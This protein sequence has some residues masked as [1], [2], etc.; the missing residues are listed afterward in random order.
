M[1]GFGLFA[2]DILGSDVDFG[3][4]AKLGMRSIL[5][6]AGKAFAASNAGAYV[7]LPSFNG[8][9]P[10]LL[11]ALRQSFGDTWGTEAGYQFFK[12]SG[13]T[14]SLPFKNVLG[15]N[16]DITAEYSMLAEG[17]LWSGRSMAHDVSVNSIYKF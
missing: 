12:D 16:F 9:M 3:L 4:G 6:F 14:L 17:A 2:N 10:R 7:V 15:A 8:S 1:L 11:V 5:A 13:L